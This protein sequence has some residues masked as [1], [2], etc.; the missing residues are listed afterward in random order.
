MKTLQQTNYMDEEI[1]YQDFQTI[2]FCCQRR[3]YIWRKKIA[4]NWHITRKIKSSLTRN[5]K[6]TCVYKNYL[7]WWR[8]RRITEDGRSKEDI[9]T[10]IS[11]DKI[12]FSRSETYCCSTFLLVW[13]KRSLNY[14]CMW[15]K[16]NWK[17]LE[18]VDWIILT[19]GV[20][21]E[22]WISNRLI[23]WERRNF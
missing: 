18:D 22:W 8:T 11:R 19:C 12:F 21:E 9:K 15:R 17:T 2:L 5:K 20:A 3:R 23:K 1:R 6:N 4:I 14:M 7:M 10:K 16:D 13:G